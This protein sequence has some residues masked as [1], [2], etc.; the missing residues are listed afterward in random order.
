L[1]SEVKTGGG[2]LA[3]LGAIAEEMSKTC[4]GRFG[5]ARRLTVQS[6]GFRE[7]RIGNLEIVALGVR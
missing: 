4:C 1:P 2:R 6:K 5:E 3:A 7:T